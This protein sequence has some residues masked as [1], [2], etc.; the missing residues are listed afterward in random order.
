MAGVGETLHTQE[1]FFFAG[2]LLSI[3]ARLT[4]SNDFANNH[5]TAAPC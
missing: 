1:Q 2:V 3:I 4:T 5:A